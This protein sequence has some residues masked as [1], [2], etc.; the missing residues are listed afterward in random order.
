[1]ITPIILAGG[2]GTRLWP[3]SRAMY[4]KQF[5]N[6]VDSEH[7]LFQQTVLRIAGMDICADPV[8]ICNDET[9]FI[10]AEQLRQIGIKSG[11]ILLEPM[12]KNTAPAVA[13][14]A[15]YVNETQPDNH[16]LVLPSDHSI[17]DELAGTKRRQG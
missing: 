1:M 13:L 12:G 10:V 7:S 6:L 8:V 5:I 9:R 4:P 15:M 16:L 2:S 11:G 17:Q 14:G 3:L